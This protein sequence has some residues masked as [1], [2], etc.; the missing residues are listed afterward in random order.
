MTLVSLYRKLK[1]IMTYV[2]QVLNLEYNDKEIKTE[3]V[4]KAS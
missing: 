4:L 3:R 2:K 1:N